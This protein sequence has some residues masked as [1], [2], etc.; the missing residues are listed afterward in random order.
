MLDK[1]SWKEL[2]LVRS[3]NLGLFVNIL[4]FN[5][6]FSLHNWESFPEE[7][8]TQLSQ[9]AKTFSPFFNGLPKFT[10]NSEYFEKK[11]LSS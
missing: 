5:G 8:Q 1:L 3:E 6:K 7:I 4:T 2:I 10:S 9:K 11:R